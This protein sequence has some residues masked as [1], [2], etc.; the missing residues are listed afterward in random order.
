[1]AYAG[2]TAQAPTISSSYRLKF[3]REE[4][5]RLI[6]SAKPKIIY[7]VKNMHF[8]SYDGFVMYTLECEREDFTQD[9]YDAIEFSNGQWAKK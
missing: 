8:F 7:N 4:F 6:Q 9:I 2:S 5:L 3:R 1:M